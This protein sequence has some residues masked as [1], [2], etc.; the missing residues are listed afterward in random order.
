MEFRKNYSS[1]VG[2]ESSDDKVATVD[3]LGVDISCA[4]SQD[5]YFKRFSI[6][7]AHKFPRYEEL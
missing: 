1:R 3:G 5:D 7:S 2:C 4:S 6:D